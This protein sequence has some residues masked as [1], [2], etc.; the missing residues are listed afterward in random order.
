ME[1]KCLKF[2]SPKGRARDPAVRREVRPGPHLRGRGPPH[3]LAA[4]LSSSVRWCSSGASPSSGYWFKASADP[5][6]W[7]E[8]SGNCSTQD[9]DIGERDAFGEKVP[10]QLPVDTSAC[11]VTIHSESN[12]A[13]T[14]NGPG[15]TWC[16]CSVIMSVAG[17]R[18]C[19]TSSPGQTDDARLWSA[20]GQFGLSILSPGNGGSLS[21]E[22]H[23][24]PKML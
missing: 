4:S 10:R 20:R 16:C 3:G 23:S 12:P 18:Q 2:D 8:S 9:H 1:K 22:L 24:G 15:P 19:T 5:A 6:G 11:W 21:R 13:V 7:R 14:A 17:S